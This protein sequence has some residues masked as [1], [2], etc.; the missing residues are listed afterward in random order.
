MIQLYSFMFLLYLYRI[1]LRVSGGSTLD[2]LLVTTELMQTGPQKDVCQEETSISIMIVERV[3]IML[4][5]CQW[6]ALAVVL[7]LIFAHLPNVLA[8]WTDMDYSPLQICITA[9]AFFHAVYSWVAYQKRPCAESTCEKQKQCRQKS[10]TVCR[11]TA[12]A[13]PRVFSPLSV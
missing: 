13:P 9:A 4:G 11:V 10:S 5:E 6:E 2:F 3:Y 1:C 8:H 7:G 12:Y